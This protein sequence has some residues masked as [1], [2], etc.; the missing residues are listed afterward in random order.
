MVGFHKIFEFLFSNILTELNENS[1]YQ[2]SCFEE[3]IIMKESIYIIVMVIA[4]VIFIKLL[5]L[6]I[7]R[8]ITKDKDKREVYQIIC[9]LFIIFALYFFNL[10]IQL[11]LGSPIPILS[12][13]VAVL[14]SF[15]IEKKMKIKYSSKVARLFAAAATIAIYF[16]CIYL[17]KIILC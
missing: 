3:E 8:K 7:F 13:C 5:D 10:D 9:C 11:R 6:A 4:F 14:F 1:Y 16:S 12:L 2:A 17:A 15:L